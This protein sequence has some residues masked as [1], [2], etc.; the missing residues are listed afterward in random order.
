MSLL[1]AFFRR[2][3]LD[4]ILDD[5]VQHHIELQV[6][7]YMQAGMAPGEAREKARQRFGGVESVKERCREENRVAGVESFWQDLKFA[8]RGFMAQP[9]LSAVL[10]AT[11]A[12]GIGANT[13][14]FSVLR[15]V[16]LQP[17]PLAEPE[18][19]VRVYETDRRSGN[20]QESASY[21]DYLDLKQ[22]LRQFEHFAGTQRMDVTL[23]GR[24]EPE[25]IRAARISSNFFAALGVQP[26]LGRVFGPGEGGVLLSYALWQR[27]FGGSRDVLGTQVRLDGF[28]GTILGVMAPEA[29]AL[30]PRSAEAWTAVE[31]VRATQ[32]RGQHTT[33]VFARLKPG[34]TIEAAQAEVSAVMARL[35]K[36]YPNDNLG[37]GGRVVPLHEDLAAN[38]RPALRV[39]SGAVALLLVIA[40]VNIA[41]LLLARASARGRE[42]AIRVSLGAGRGRLTRQLLTESLLLA[43]SGGILGLAVGFAG[44]KGL[45][46]LA[47][48]DMPLIGR[49]SLDGTVL[50]VTFGISMAAWLIFGVLPAIRSSAMPPVAGLQGS[51]GNTAS[52]GSM[53]LRHGL[54]MTQIALAAVLVIFSG[55]LIRSFWRLRHADLGY[56][57][58]GTISVQ[59]KLPETR[60]PYPQFPYLD[61]P[62]VFGFHDRLNAALDEIPGIEA[63]SLAITGPDRRSWTTGVTVDGRPIPPPREQEEAQFR[64][65]DPDYLAVI[66]G[67]LRSGRFFTA[68][69]D[70]RHPLV[71]VVNEAFVRRY[72]PGEDPLGNR[73]RVYNTLRTIVGV[74]GD[75]RYGGPGLPIQPTMYMSIR[76]FPFPDTTLIVRTKGDPAAAANALRQAVFSADPNV[77]P[78]EI[79]TLEGALRNAT[80]RERFVT[81]L[82]TAFATVALL[83]AT[84]GIYGVVAFSVGRRRQEIALRLALGAKGRDLFR[85]I[86]GGTLIRTVGAVVAGCVGALGVAR[87]VEPLVSGTGTYET[88]TYLTVAAV[89]LATALLGATIPLKRALRSASSSLLLRSE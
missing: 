44:V 13:A 9:G 80:A 16:M 5:E 75:I 57:P 12:L 7:E 40:C 76:Q 35:E 67:R 46:A 8:A 70:E 26:V 38:M 66:K 34:A 1:R 52:R 43:V 17:L 73:I 21:P 79:T 54:V 20:M 45:I 74:I 63:A 86:A 64:T 3:R 87:I 41:N 56:E 68:D 50:A 23:T 71:A 27:K 32:F 62:A 4:Q 22:S 31:I 18:R 51:V 15:A 49:T 82:L 89:I 42:L 6:K 53:R 84:V 58:R 11:L 29:N 69:D 61:W 59:M 83:L 36:E 60:Y 19:I 48:Q 88:S 39:L 30:S 81:T 33:A 28:T 65:A 25:R 2:R 85:Q 10:L 24:G 72:F 55:V 47:P 37:R 14:V 77:A 78:F